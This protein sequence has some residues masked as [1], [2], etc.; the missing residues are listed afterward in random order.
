M[1]SQSST[2][3]SP[4]LTL[5]PFGGLGLDLA[6]VRRK[7]SGLLLVPFQKQEAPWQE[8]RLDAPPVLSGVELLIRLGRET[9]GS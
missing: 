6:E 3:Q 4:G 1:H 2:D 8:P 7:V 5:L 9:L